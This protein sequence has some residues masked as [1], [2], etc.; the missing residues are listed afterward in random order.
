MGPVNPY[1]VDELSDTETEPMNTSN[2]KRIY[3]TTWTNITAS[4]PKGSKVS[5]SFEVSN[6]AVTM[7]TR[8]RTVRT[9]D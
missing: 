1:D 7:I 9:P 3:V 2:L 5:R 8:L 6:A 4:T